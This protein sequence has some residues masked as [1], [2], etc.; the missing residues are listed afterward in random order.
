M[1]EGTSCVFCQPKNKTI[2]VRQQKTTNKCFL[3]CLNI[4]QNYSSGDTESGRNP[5]ILRG[6]LKTKR[7]LM[8]K[9]RI[10]YKLHCRNYDWGCLTGTIFVYTSLVA[11]VV[12]IQESVV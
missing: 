3:T 1:C 9:E 2:A 6:G 5:N 8:E 10:W 11:K 7:F 4:F 12:I